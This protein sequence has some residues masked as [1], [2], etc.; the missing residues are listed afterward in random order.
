M[1][2]LFCKFLCLYQFKIEICVLTNERKD[3]KILA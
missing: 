2:F 3:D 1:L